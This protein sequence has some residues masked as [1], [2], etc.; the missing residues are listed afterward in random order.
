M[1]SSKMEEKKEKKKK[2]NPAN[3]RPDIHQG[4]RSSG[5]RTHALA[6]PTQTRARSH[7]LS[8]IY[9]EGNMLIALEWLIIAP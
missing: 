6:L 7:S 1:H 9:R 4:E 5:A 2:S 3:Y 8:C